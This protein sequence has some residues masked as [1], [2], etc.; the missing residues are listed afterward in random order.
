MHVPSS[1][2]CRSISGKGK[3]RCRAGAES[4]AAVGKVLFFSTFDSVERGRVTLAALGRSFIALYR[5]GDVFG[6]EILG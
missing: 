2:S 3:R 6:V 4:R 1:G 5:C